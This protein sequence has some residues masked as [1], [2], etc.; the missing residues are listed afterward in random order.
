[1]Y[2]TEIHFP[3]LT[4][5]TSG[6]T[7]SVSVWKSGLSVYSGCFFLDQAHGQVLAPLIRIALSAAGIEVA[8]LAAIAV[9]SGP[10]SYTGLRI[11]VSLAKGLCFGRNIPLLS[12]STMEN[13][14]FQA[15]VKYPYI[16]QVLVCLDARRDEVYAAL[17]TRDMK[18]TMPT[19]ACRLAGLPMADYTEEC[20]VLA[21]DGATKTANHFGYPAGWALDTTL[22]PNSEAIGAWLASGLS[23]KSFEKLADFEP[24]YIKPVYITQGKP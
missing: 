4:I 15:F 24:E 7:C 1:M 16:Q 9:G 10:G 20:L 23:L 17:L 19:M 18:F 22:Y 2:K 14:A 11:G 8:Q 6:P 21:G 13:I 3:L 12:V 5:E